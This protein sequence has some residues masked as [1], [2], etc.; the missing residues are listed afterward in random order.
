MKPVLLLCLGTCF[1]ISLIIFTGCK[2]TV[3]KEPEKA[4]VE[5]TALEKTKPG[6]VIF[7]SIPLGVE[8]YIDGELK[9]TTP[10]TLQLEDGKK[11]KVEFK[12]EAHGYETETREIDNKAGTINVS[13]R[14]KREQ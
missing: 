9:G 1:L 8:V 6:T 14:K 2:E 5:K 4:T 3:L 7:N 13:L 11:Y 12:D 10:L